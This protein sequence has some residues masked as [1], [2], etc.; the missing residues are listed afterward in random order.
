[1]NSQASHSEGGPDE[2]ARIAQGFGLEEAQRHFQDTRLGPYL[3]RLS[4][5]GM[6]GLK[7]HGRFREWWSTIDAIPSVEERKLELDCPCPRVVASRAGLSVTEPFRRLGPWKKGPFSVFGTE[8]DAE[9]RCDQKWQ[10]VQD[11]ASP[12]SG[13]RVLDVGTGNG[14]YLL[15]ALGNGAAFVLGLEPSVHNSCQFLALARCFGRLDLALLPLCAEQFA[16]DCSLFDTVLSMGVLY[17]R[18]CPLDHLAA[19]RGFLRPGGE[20]ILETMVVAGIEGYSLLPRGR[21][22]GMRN[23]WFLPTVGT[24]TSWLHRLGFVNI[25][26]GACVPTS[27]EEQRATPWSGPVSLVDF[28]DPHDP[29]RTIEGYPAP[30][31][32]ILTARAAA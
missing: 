22:A 6:Q 2:S 4:A 24:L 19:L 15:R 23:V 27:A 18:R 32:A 25:N 11:I 17:H 26:V 30:V 10:R 16:Q 1:M 20:L 9:W 14:Y 7:Q 8:I 21:Y 31:R 5:V 13:R 3:E 12:L 29:G 28:L